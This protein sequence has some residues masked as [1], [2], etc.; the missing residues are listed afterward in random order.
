[1]PAGAT[2][3][4]L[5]GILLDG[6][7]IVGIQNGLAPPRVV[8]FTLDQAGERVVAT[9]VLDRHLP[10][11]DE[12]TNVTRLNNDLIYIANSQWEKYADDGS[13]RP[14]TRL[15]PTVLLALPLR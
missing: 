11:A 7:S 14:G 10:L 8:R 4:G 3:L 2:S 12:P 15:G 6:R 1:M 5:D 13:R 9:E